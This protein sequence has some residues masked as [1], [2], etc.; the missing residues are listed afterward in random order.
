[1]TSKESIIH[2]GVAAASAT[3]VVGATAYGLSRP[4]E[5][6]PSQ[7]MHELIPI[8][9]S[10]VTNDDSKNII[11]WLSTTTM[12]MVDNARAVRNTGARQFELSRPRLLVSAIKKEVAQE[13]HCH[14]YWRPLVSGPAGREVANICP[15]NS[16]LP[17]P[18]VTLH[19]PLKLQLPSL[20]DFN[21][22][23][24]HSKLDQL[25][26]PMQNDADQAGAM[27]LKLLQSHE[28][29]YLTQSKTSPVPFFDPLGWSPAPAENQS[30]Q[31]MASRSTSS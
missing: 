27:T 14:P 20:A 15:G 9:K 26:M 28:Q 16:L 13:D 1:M 10:D 4:R 17:Q 2:Y 11:D 5:R 24:D 31:N 8:R 30:H 29:N 18:T 23:F 21:G 22:V 7:P 3:L 6:V 25:Y 19:P 12:P